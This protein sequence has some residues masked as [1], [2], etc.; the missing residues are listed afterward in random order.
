MR[1]DPL[2][3]SCGLTITYVPPPSEYPGVA[4]WPKSKISCHIAPPAQATQHSILASLGSP[5]TMPWPAGKDTHPLDAVG[6]PLPAG[7][8]FPEGVIIWLPESV[9]GPLIVPLMVP[10]ASWRVVPEVSLKV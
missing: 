4:A 7:A 5:L 8:G 6:N 1:K 3:P 9:T 2:M 10:T